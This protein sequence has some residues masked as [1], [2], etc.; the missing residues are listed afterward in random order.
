MLGSS[1]VA[2]QL[3]ASRE[4]LG[5]MSVLVKHGCY[6]NSSELKI[7]R[8]CGI[9]KQNVRGNYGRYMY[10]FLSNAF[11]HCY[12]AICGCAFFKVIVES[13]SLKDDRGWSLLS[14]SID[15]W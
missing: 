14:R 2:A 9:L 1:R 8:S 11:R 5:S 12:A 6:G 13:L 4:G 7:G 10:I 15:L 3:A